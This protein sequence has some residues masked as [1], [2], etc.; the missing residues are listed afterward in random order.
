[1]PASALPPHHFP[2]TSITKES[3]LNQ[4][5]RGWPLLHYSQMQAWFVLWPPEPDFKLYFIVCL[6]SLQI[7]SCFYSI[8]CL[9]ISSL[10]TSY[11]M[12]RLASRAGPALV[13]TS[14]ILVNMP[15]VPFENMI[16]DDIA[17]AKQPTC[18]RK[19][20]SQTLALMMEC[21][22]RQHFG[23][24]CSMVFQHRGQVLHLLLP[25]SRFCLSSSSGW[26]TFWLFAPG[27]DSFFLF[28]RPLICKMRM[29]VRFQWE[30]ILKS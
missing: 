7:P 21:Q 20:S 15:Q 17:W 24:H 30:Y 12:S 4:P 13:I 28:L 26:V 10:G 27:Q 3:L 23:H 5:D 25:G 6:S 11:S 16:Y 18:V 8:H 22:C 1:M 14:K 19:L 9:G 29:V 2:Y